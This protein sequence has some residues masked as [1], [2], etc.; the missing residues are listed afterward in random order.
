MMW[1]FRSAGSSLALRISWFKLL[2][3]SATSLFSF[4]RL[5]GGRL[6]QEIVSQE[7]PSFKGPGTMLVSF[8]IVSLHLQSNR[9]KGGDC[10]LAS[11]E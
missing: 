2:P 10:F 4:L 9:V 6:S 5:S 11:I 8:L 1:P 3:D 7:I